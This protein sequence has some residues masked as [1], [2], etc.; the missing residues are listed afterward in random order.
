MTF[1]ILKNAGRRLP[2]DAQSLIGRQPAF[3]L[4][5][6]ERVSWG[7]YLAVPFVAALAALLGAAFHRLTLGTRSKL[8]LQK[9]VPAWLLP[10]AGGV[11]TWAVGIAVF[12]TT[13]RTGV[14]GLGYHD[15][16]AVLDKNGNTVRGTITLHDLIRAQGV[17]QN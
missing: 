7:H 10:V 13:G 4:P 12:W 11:I 9:R 14:F 6:V 2:E 15:L 5:S 8:R 1:G 3:S 16:S 17:L